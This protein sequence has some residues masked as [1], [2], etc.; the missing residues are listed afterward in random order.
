MLL[1]QTFKTFAITAMQVVEGLLYLKIMNS[2]YAL[3]PYEKI[4]LTVMIELA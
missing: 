3:P 4:S 1:A 2:P